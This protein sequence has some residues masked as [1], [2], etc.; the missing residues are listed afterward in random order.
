M[1]EPKGTPDP[2]E[3]ARTVLLQ[4]AEL[5]VRMISLQRSVV[6]I[7]TRQIGINPSRSEEI[8]IELDAH[9][10][11]ERD[12]LYRLWLAQA[13]IAPRSNDPKPPKPADND[14]R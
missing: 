12:R 1:S 11:V 3:F 4:L 14:R 9:Q 13:K 10:T 8:L 6:H 2:N 7:L 5:Q